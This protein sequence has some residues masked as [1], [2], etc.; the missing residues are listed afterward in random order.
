MENGENDYVIISAT[1]PS[2]E[3]VVFLRGSANPSLYLDEFVEVW[4][5]FCCFYLV[6]CLSVLVWCVGGQA[7]AFYLVFS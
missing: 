4:Q 5:Q 7:H 3:A 6:C 1:A 2:G